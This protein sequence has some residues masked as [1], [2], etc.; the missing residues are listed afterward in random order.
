MPI[1][2]IILD[3]NRN[4]EISSI[5]SV[6]LIIRVTLIINMNL[7]ADIYQLIILVKLV[8]LVE[9]LMLIIPDGVGRLIAV[10]YCYQ[11]N[12]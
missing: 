10:E 6:I 7:N 9:S 8:M 4:A 5:I 3:E 1:E 2:L 11:Q 12:Y